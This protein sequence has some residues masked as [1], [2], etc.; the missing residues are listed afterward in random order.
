MIEKLMDLP[1]ILKIISV[2]ASGAL[3]PG[4]MTASSVAMGAKNGWKA[5]LGIAF[6]HTLVEFPFVLITAYGLGTF[7]QIFWVRTLLGLAGGL[8]LLFFGFLAVR[9][10]ISVKGFDTPNSKPKY[11]SAITLGIMLTLFNPYFLAWWIGVGAPLLMEALTTI[12]LATLMIFYL[13]HVWLDYSF[14]M[15]I[16]AIGSVPKK[17][18]RIYKIILASL[19][20]MILYFGVEMIVNTLRIIL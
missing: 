7:F 3:A 9:D 10:I 12:S 18:L 15:I 20:I 4:P 6:G 13:A 8:F 5:G 11:N 2:S 17:N 1:M 19:A 16:S 14:L